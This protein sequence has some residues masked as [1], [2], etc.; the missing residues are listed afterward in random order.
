MQCN[1][2]TKKD[3]DEGIRECRCG[4]VADLKEYLSLNIWN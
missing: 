2:T 4:G 3:E 1:V